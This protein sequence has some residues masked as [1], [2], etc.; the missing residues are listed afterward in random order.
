MHAVAILTDV[1]RRASASLSL[2]DDLQHGLVKCGLADVA[3]DAAASNQIKFEKSP[4]TDNMDAGASR[5][6]RNGLQVDRGGGV[7]QHALCFLS[8]V[9]HLV[10]DD[11][12]WATEGLIS[13][14]VASLEFGGDA[15]KVW[16]ASVVCGIGVRDVGRGLLIRAGALSAAAHTAS[17][18]RGNGVDVEEG[19]VEV[20]AVLCLDLSA[21]SEAVSCGALDLMINTLGGREPH[22]AIHLRCLEAMSSLCLHTTVRQDIARRGDAK[23]ALVSMLSSPSSALRKRAAHVLASL[24][25]N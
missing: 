8:R 2:R 25:R 11:Q 5:D 3:R 22:S 23:T 7:R 16:A 6:G 19:A 18:S 14:A 4:G 15:E 10:A 12:G 17:G 24:P 21:A 20:I 13:A 1:H 9:I